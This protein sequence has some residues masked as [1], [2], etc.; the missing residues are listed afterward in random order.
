ERQLLINQQAQTVDKDGRV[1]VLML[2]RREEPGYA[3]PN[4]T[5]A[6]YST[7]GTAYY[8][9]FRDPTTGA[10]SQRRL[11][12]TAYPVGSRPKIGYDA[13]G[14]LYAVY[15]SYTTT[16]DVVAGGL[17]GKL[18]VASASKASD[19]TDWEVV[20]VLNTT[21][22]GEPII[23]QDRLLADNILSVYI[24]ENSTGTGAVGTPLHVIDFAVNVPEPMPTSLAL[25]GQD[26]VMSIMATPDS[27]YQLQ[28]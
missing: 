6:T 11:P 28:T 10:W 2:H 14:N 21:C 9:Y 12:P 27:R 17:P 23:D 24:Q 26:D 18:V 15:L 16:A 8:H 13:G 3:Y 7:R 19:Y 25:F 4:V 20:Q 1:H 22:Y 5:T